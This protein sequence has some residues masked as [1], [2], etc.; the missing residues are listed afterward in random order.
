MTAEPAL[1]LDEEDDEEEEEEEAGDSEEPNCSFVTGVRIAEPIDTE[2]KSED[3]FRDATELAKRYI[4]E[5]FVDKMMHCGGS[6]PK[7]FL[8]DPKRVKC[9]VNYSLSKGV[10]RCYAALKHTVTDAEK[11]ACRKTGDSTRDI[12][13]VNETLNLMARSCVPQEFAGGILM[14]Y[15]EFVEGVEF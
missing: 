9:V 1:W 13:L 12:K 4:D 5:F 10:T 3:V 7:R 6:I 11:A 15:L 2:I 14:M 8:H